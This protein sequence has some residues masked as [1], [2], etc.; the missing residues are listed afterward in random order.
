MG[1]SLPRRAQPRH[2]FGV[3][4]LLPP[5]L[6]RAGDQVL[7]LRGTPGLGLG[8]SMVWAIAEAHGGTVQV[9]SRPGEGAAFTLV[10]PRKAAAPL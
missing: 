5:A 6:V 7:V 8:L 9:E 4:I 3:D 1:P 2:A 10:L